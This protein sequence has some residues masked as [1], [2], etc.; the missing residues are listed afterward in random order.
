MKLAPGLVDALVSG[1]HH[2]HPR[3]R[4]A[5]HALGCVICKPA[6]DGSLP[7]GAL[8]RLA[9]LAE[10]DPN[11]RVRLAARHSLACRAAAEPA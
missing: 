6:W 3:G 1:V 2:P 8:D 9:E 7:P 11:A 4:N 5:A 10:S